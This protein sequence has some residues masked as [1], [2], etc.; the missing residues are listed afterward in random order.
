MRSHNIQYSK[1][2][3]S[4]ERW[5]GEGLISAFKCSSLKVTWVTSVHSALVRNSHLDASS[6]RGPRKCNPVL[7]QKWKEPE[8]L[9]KL[10]QWWPQSICDKEASSRKKTTLCFKLRNSPLTLYYLKSGEVLWWSQWKGQ[11]RKW[12]PEGIL[13]ERFCYPLVTF[14]EQQHLLWWMAPGSMTFKCL[15]IPS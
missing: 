4:K 6:H 7:L 1:L 11:E 8:M 12:W 14:I 10:H 3:Y 13:Q 2:L 15:S 5:F 9:G